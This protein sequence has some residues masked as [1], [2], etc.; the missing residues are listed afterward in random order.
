MKA[1]GA[2]NHRERLNSDPRARSERVP[3][4]A[5]CGNSWVQ[6]EE[7]VRSS[8]RGTIGGTF[9]VCKT[10]RRLLLR[11]G[12]EAAMSHCVT[13]V[14]GGP[15]S[16]HEDDRR[17]PCLC[18]PCASKRPATR[19]TTYRVDFRGLGSAGCG[20]GRNIGDAGAR[21]HIRDGE[22]RAWTGCCVS[23][24][25]F[26]GAQLF[27]CHVSRRLRNGPRGLGPS[28][29]IP[30]MIS[31]KADWANVE[32]PDGCLLERTSHSADRWHDP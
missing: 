30:S 5:D 20:H 12:S 32:L 3:S 10:S 18:W 25:G 6:E 27:V 23:R 14:N 15:A 19:V 16:S 7:S 24:R 1:K 9:A 4:T 2:G 28:E 31:D 13:T 29:G 17:G 21:R 22:N 11:W 8:V 26:A